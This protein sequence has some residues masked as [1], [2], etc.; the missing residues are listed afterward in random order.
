M[1]NKIAG[2]F[3]LISSFEAE[4]DVAMVATHLQMSQGLISSLH[5]VVWYLATI[6]KYGLY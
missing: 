5:L 6:F 3:F 4:I 2:C 1:H